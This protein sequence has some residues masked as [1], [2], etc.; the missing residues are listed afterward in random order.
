VRALGRVAGVVGVGFRPW[1]CYGKAAIG[2]GLF[3]A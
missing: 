3:G 1:G 2:G